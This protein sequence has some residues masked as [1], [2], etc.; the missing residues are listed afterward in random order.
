MTQTQLVE[1]EYPLC[2]HEIEITSQ[3]DL[4]DHLENT[5]TLPATEAQRLADQIYHTLAPALMA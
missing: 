1:V 5:H 4:Q 3:I 2:A